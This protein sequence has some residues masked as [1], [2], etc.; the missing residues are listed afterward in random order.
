MILKWSDYL[1]AH[2]LNQDY[3][4]NTGALQKLITTKETPENSFRHLTDNKS[5]VC[6]SRNDLNGHLQAHFNHT[7]LKASIALQEPDYLALAGFGRR[8]TPVRLNPKEIFK[9]PRNKVLVPAFKDILNCKTIDDIK[10]LTPSKK[11]V[12]VDCY[13]LLPPSLTAEILE[14]DNFDPAYLIIKM[15]NKINLIHAIANPENIDL[16]EEQEKKDGGDEAKDETKEPTSEADEDNEEE[17]STHP[18]EPSFGRI[19]NFFYWTVMDTKTIESTR[20]RP[21]FKSTTDAW[22][23]QQHIMC[24]GMNEPQKKTEKPTPPQDKSSSQEIIIDLSQIFCAL[25]QAMRDKTLSD[26]QRDAEKTGGTGKFKKMAPMMRNSIIMFTMVPN[27][28]QEDLD[29]INP[30][31][32]FL[33]ILA[34]KS[35]SVVRDTLHHMMKTKGCLVCL[36]D[37]MC[38]AIK[39]GSIQSTDIYDINGLTP[40]HCG[41]EPCGKQLSIEERAVLEETAALG[42]ITKEDI[43]LL[44]KSENYLPKDFWAYEHQVKNFAM[45]CELLGGPDCLTARTWKG[46]ARHAQIQ[47]ATYRRLEKENN[48]F[49]ICLLDELHRKTQS[50][51]HSCAHGRVDEL[52]VRQLDFS[53]I[54]N[55]IEGHKYYAKKPLWLPRDYNKRKAAAPQ[56]VGGGGGALNNV[57]PKKRQ[58]NNRQ[59]GDMVFNQNLQQDMKVPA[60]TT[61]HQVFAPEF[62]KGIQRRNHHDGTEKCNNFHHRGRCDSKCPRIASHAKTL[63]AEDIAQGKAYVSEVLKKFNASKGNNSSNGKEST[64]QN[65]SSNSDSK[66]EDKPNK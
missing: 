6:V 39:N 48:I 64:N 14:E 47:Q 22:S 40:F 26:M 18:L 37:G 23:E 11:K 54:F 51:I 38:A 27:M 59:R 28:E 44:T 20:V 31:E 17:D 1:R 62:T 10:A 63:T 36:Q 24:L 49:Y 7:M 13:A 53:Q 41:P 25:T 65:Q 32:T 4:T 2:P 3:D 15:I 58:F 8:A 19:M 50:F 43:S 56:V 21:C 52:N 5:I 45:L 46:V 16:T 61:Y 29:E 12:S 60:P 30:T 66:G 35:G 42:K 55:E 57:T 33:S 34:M 9:H